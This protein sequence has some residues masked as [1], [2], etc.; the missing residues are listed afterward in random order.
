MYKTTELFDIITKAENKKEISQKEHTGILTQ[1]SKDIVGW[2]IEALLKGTSINEFKKA[3]HLLNNENG[4]E[5]SAVAVY[6]I[7]CFITYDE[8]TLLIE[9]IKII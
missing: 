3:R 7:N 9:G 6:G 8:K 2:Y 4:T 1:D 5:T